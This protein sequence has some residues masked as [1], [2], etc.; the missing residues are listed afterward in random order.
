MSTYEKCWKPAK[1]LG[2]SIKSVNIQGISLNNWIN[3]ESQSTL[4]KELMSL[5]SINE[6]KIAGSKSNKTF[7][8]IYLDEI[9]Y[10]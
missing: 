5:E 4:F 10:F 8:S 3:K 9:T 6:K 2:K 7:N 1:N